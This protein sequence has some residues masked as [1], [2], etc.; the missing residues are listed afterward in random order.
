M[1]NHAAIPRRPLGDHGTT[2]SILGLGGYHLGAVSSAK[3]ATRIVH[4]ALD[5]GIDFFDNAWEYHQGESERRLGNAL[6]GRRDE[7][8]V[9]TKAC[10]HGRDKRT[11]LRMLDESLRRLKTDYLDLWQL[12]EVVYEN[13]PEL[14][15]KRGG[16][17]EALLAAK[18]AGKVRFI[19][20]TGHKD[21]NIHL[22]ML[23]HDFPF[24]TC[25]LPLNCFDAQF[26]SF[27]E[28]VLPELLR[29]DIAAIGMKSLCGMGVPVKRRVITAEEG[30]RYAMSLPVVTTVSGIDSLKVLR[31]NLAIAR[32]FRRWSAAQMNALRKKASE[33]A[34]DG[35]FELYKISM[36]HDA[37]VGRKQHGV[38]SQ[39][40][41]GM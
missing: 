24:D 40:E 32:G 26:R 3:E 1:T 35:R 13:E 41:M 10:T 37:D 21:P 39:K 16:A 27:E 9:M 33:S 15:F 5:A 34:A 14:Y 7:A 17:I 31:Q 12:H 11:A 20:F 28:R 29:Q 25:Q 4:E 2:I 22:K 8:F 38:P 18:E 19:G 6:R 30:L 36:T 23:S